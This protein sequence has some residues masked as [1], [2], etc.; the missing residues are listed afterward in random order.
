MRLVS[1]LALMERDLEFSRWA[2]LWVLAKETGSCWRSETKRDAWEKGGR[3]GHG[4]CRKGSA[5]M[6][7]WV[8]AQGNVAVGR[9]GLAGRDG[10]R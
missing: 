10:Y 7:G 6:E 4:V 5:R 8:V 9:M 2:N 3:N 1:I